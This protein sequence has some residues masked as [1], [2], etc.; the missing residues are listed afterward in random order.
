MGAE[1]RRQAGI[2]Q[3]PLEQAPHVIGRE[4]CIRKNLAVAQSRPEQWRILG[5]GVDPGP[6]EVLRDPAVEVVTDGDL[7]LLAALFPEPEDPLGPLVLQIRAAKACNGA[8]PGSGVGQGAEERLIAHAHDVGG[9]DRAGGRP[10][11]VVELVE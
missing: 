7:A 1:D 8:D 10:G 9:V 11:D 2:I 5:I 3:P 6:L 4:G